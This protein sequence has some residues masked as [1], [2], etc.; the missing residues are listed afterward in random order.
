MFRVDALGDS[1][2]R[3]WEALW[4]LATLAIRITVSILFGRETDAY[5]Y[6]VA[7]VRLPRCFDR[8]WQFCNNTA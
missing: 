4:D 1:V 6:F 2:L 8:H 7:R 3:A 5:P